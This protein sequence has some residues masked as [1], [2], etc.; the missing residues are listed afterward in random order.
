[1][2]RLEDVGQLGLG[3]PVQAGHDSVEFGEQRLPLPG[4]NAAHRHP[5]SP[6]PV[7]VAPVH[8]SEPAG[9]LLHPPPIRIVP[10]GPRHRE[11]VEQI[12]V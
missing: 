1:V 9:D 3:Q 7:G 8:R 12:Q 2:E 5:D 10:A 4:G 11:G 6:G